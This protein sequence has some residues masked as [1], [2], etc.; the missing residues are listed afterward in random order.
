MNV[1]QRSRTLRDGWFW[2]QISDV[3]LLFLMI[4]E[5]HRLALILRPQERL[6][7]CLRTPHRNSDEIFIEAGLSPGHHLDEVVERRGYNVFRCFRF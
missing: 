7:G 1:N 4:A 3:F 5:N 6:W 2:P